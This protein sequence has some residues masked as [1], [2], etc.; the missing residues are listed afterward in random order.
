M[1]G[2]EPALLMVLDLIENQKI[3]GEEAIQLI[4][5]IPTSFKTNSVPVLK[6]LMVR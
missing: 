5:T 6:K 3:V 1:A 4:S 2:T